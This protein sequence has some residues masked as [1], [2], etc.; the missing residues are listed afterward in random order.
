M[1]DDNLFE[2]TGQQDQQTQQS[3]APATPPAPQLDLSPVVNE[4]KALTQRIV[5]VEDFLQNVSNQQ[6]QQAAPA[7]PLNDEDLSTQL[8]TDPKGTLEK[9][10]EE[11]AKQKLGPA[12]QTQFAD[13]RDELVD[14]HRSTIDGEFG[15][16]TWDELF[17][18][19]LQDAFKNMPPEMAAS[20]GH[21]RVMVNAIKGDKL[22]QLVEK[23]AALEEKAEQEAAAEPPAMLGAGHARPAEPTISQDL[24]DFLQD[25]NK[26]L[27]TNMSVKE[28]QELAAKGDTEDDWREEAKE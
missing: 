18:P 19:E 12:L 17:V 28:W 27:G 23:A 26:A 21:L 11:F 10:F 14:H 15:S 24:K 5:Q 4:I 7:P 20:R 22:D 13:R 8:L 6:Q 16:G 9:Q 1:V 3:A 2:G 25:Q